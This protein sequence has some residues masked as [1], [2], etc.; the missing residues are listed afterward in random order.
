MNFYSQFIAVKNAC[1][2]VFYSWYRNKVASMA[3][4]SLLMLEQFTVTRPTASAATTPKLIFPM[5]GNCLS[6]SYL[7]KKIRETY[8]FGTPHTFE[9]KAIETVVIIIVPGYWVTNIVK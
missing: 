7:D 3:I 9:H 6:H 1:H 8:F 2:Y 5:Y 4:G